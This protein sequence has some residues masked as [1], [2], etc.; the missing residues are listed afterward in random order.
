MRRWSD[1]IQLSKLHATRAVGGFRG[2]GGVAPAVMMVVAIEL[3]AGTHSNPGD[4]AVLPREC[5]TFLPLVQSRSRKIRRVPIRPL[6]DAG[7]RWML[8]AQGETCR[9]PCCRDAT[10]RPSTRM[11]RPR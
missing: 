4:A 8:A 6:T 5:V 9:D 7:A 11:A 3:L 2:L 10:E 1:V